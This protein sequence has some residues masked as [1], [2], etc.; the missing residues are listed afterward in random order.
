MKSKRK[1]RILAVVLCMVIM[2]S[3]SSFIFASGGTEDGT[4]VS[5]EGGQQEVQTQDES[6]PSET[7]VSVQ[8]ETPQETEIPDPEVTPTPE[9]TP[10]PTAEPTAAPTPTEAPE[11]TTTPETSTTPQPTTAPETV[12]DEGETTET[13][14]GT[15]S[16]DAETTDVPVDL[17]EVQIAQAFDESYEDSDV[18]IRVTADAG[19]VPEGAELSVTP[20]VKRDVTDD[21]TDE[22]KEKVEAVNAQYDLTEKKLTEDSE[23]NE[24]VMEGFLAYDISFL[25]N[26]KEVEPNGDVKVVMEFREAAIP[27]GVSEDAEVS[28]KHLKEDEEAEDGVVVENMAEKA[29]VQ[30]TDKAEVE[31][32]ELTSDSFSTFT[33]YWGKNNRNVKVHYVN[34]SGVE[35]TVKGA[36]E[37]KKVNDGDWV[38]LSQYAIAIDNCRYQEA[39]L[40]SYDGP[41]AESIQYN[42]KKWYYKTNSESSNDER[43]WSVDGG[44][45]HV[46][47]VYEQEIR[48]HFVSGADGSELGPSMSLEDFFNAYVDGTEATDDIAP[49]F[50]GYRFVKTSISSTYNEYEQTTKTE[51]YNGQTLWLDGKYWALQLQ[52][53]GDNYEYNRVSA[54]AAGNN[55]TNSSTWLEIDN[56]VFFIY[57]PDNY[58][59]TT[60]NSTSDGITLNLFNYTLDINNVSWEAG[61]PFYNGAQNHVDGRGGT[62]TGGEVT[63]VLGEDGFPIAVATDDNGQTINTS[64]SFLF[65][66]TEV[67]GTTGPMTAN[68]LFTYNESNYSYEYDSQ[69]NHAYYD[70]EDQRFY[71]Y[72]YQLSPAGANSYS[73]FQRGNFLPFNDV[74]NPQQG[75]LNFVQYG[76]DNRTKV[77]YWYGMSM[78]MNFY[79]PEDGILPNGDEMLFEFRGDDDVFVYLDGVLILDL[80]GIHDAY[81]GTINFSTGTII[82][83][84]NTIEDGIYTRYSESGLFTTEQLNEMFTEITVDGKTRHI[85][86]DYKTVEMD[87]FYLER[88]AGA[89]NCHIKFNMPP[90]P[91]ETIIVGK[92]I[93]DA[94]AS[95]YSDVEFSFMLETKAEGQ[96]EYNPV[97]NKTV[98]VYDTSGNF[99]RDCVVGGDGIF[100]LKHGERAYFTDYPVT[101]EYRVTEIGVNSEEYDQVTITGVTVTQVGPEG[102]STE[103]EGW[104]TEELTVADTPMVVFQNRIAAGNKRELHITKQLSSY[105]NNATYQIQVFF[106]NEVNAENGTPYTGKYWIDEV[107]HEA[108]NGIITL[109]KGQTASIVDI[110][111]G[112]S[113]KVVEVNLDNEIY[114]APTYTV[115]NADSIG[116]IGA[117]TG[118]LVLGADTEVTVTNSMKVTIPDP[119]DPESVP[120]NKQIDW[121]GDDDDNPDTDLTG[122]YY[123]RLYLDVTGIPTEEPDP[124]DI[125]LILDYSS[126]M[127]SEYGAGSRMNAVKESAKTAVN[128][129]LPNGSSNKVGIVWFDKRATDNSINLPFTDDKND[130]LSNIDERKP[131]N[132]TNYQS[133]F[134]VAQEMLKRYRIEGRNQYVIFVTDGEP[135]QWVD[136]NGEIQGTGIPDAK[137]HAIEQAKEFVGLSGFYAVSVGGETGMDFLRTVVANVNAG[138][139]DTIE[140]KNEEQ[141]VSTFQQILGSI[142]RQ[143]SNVTITDTLSKYVEFVNENGQTIAEQQVAEN[144]MESNIALKVTKTDKGSTDIEELTAGTDYTYTIENDTVTVNFGENYFLDPGAKYTI[145][146]NVKLTEKAFDDYNANFESGLSGGGYDGIIGDPNTDYGDNDTSSEQP[147]FHSNTKAEFS[148]EIEGADEPITGTYD[149]PVVQ[150]QERTDWKIVKKSA[151]EGGTNLAGAEFTLTGTVGGEQ[152]S[153]SGES[154]S[155]NPDTEVS[156]LGYIRWMDEDGLLILENTIPAGVYTLTETKAPTGYALSA[157]S[158]QVIVKN[159]EAPEIRPILGDD[160][161]DAALTAKEV[162]DD[163]GNF[164]YYQ[165]EIFNEALYELPSAG[166]SGIYWYLMGGT[167]LMITA[168]FILYRNK[169]KE[170]LGS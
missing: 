11:N 153:F 39:R 134:I 152:L 161:F 110:P 3:N 86:T 91:D 94:N 60:R 97:T 64:L 84:N 71:V 166:G 2:L 104:Q 16:S 109:Q 126:S 156:E 12:T 25:I 93:T 21:M 15:N 89:A 38:E 90:I 163:E 54:H 167:L 137:T 34:T 159:M 78:N 75:E 102:D 147:G 82:E 23:E 116:T 30:T 33:I 151:S 63:N 158:W 13:E 53:N 6:T 170:V 5:Q 114:N 111:S 43:N 57:K 164:L 26:G 47:L 4:A 143:I 141:L 100:K 74:I 95:V 67:S 35:I 88:G 103:I 65:G 125:L 142:T 79:Q 50:D 68:Y 129:L 29:D 45:R 146:F 127:G 144:I 118:K 36:E 58:Q 42:K 150:I 51:T 135:Y 124:A 132:G 73:A 24:E 99:V 76:Q 17:D 10:T 31:K 61:F 7:E 19:I 168:S 44:E 14:R 128:T 72:D 138:I 20:V 162:E 119:T 83:N 154:L 66:N 140:A 98:K 101:T 62:N 131:D 9:A 121:L 85:F 117:A 139:K 136:S 56:Q 108:T 169:R 113:F 155:D 49:E 157:V 165:F 22:E 70:E 27:E 123:Y 115:N 87:F 52:K 122:D 112:T 92:Q 69:S 130:L 80:G 105:D 77:D 1:R 148:Y 81:P 120:H 18:V 48:V 59:I 160:Q 40:N 8:S 145:S 32:V 96:T 46:Y 133:A 106:G 55:A 37:D 41:V 28:V 107:P 149:D